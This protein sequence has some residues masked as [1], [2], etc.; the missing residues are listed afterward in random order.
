MSRIVWI[1][2]AHLNFC[3]AG[4][5][6]DFLELVRR[7]H[8]AAVLLG[9]DIGEAQ[10][11][12]DYLTRMACAWPL[13][14]YFVLGNHDFYYGSIHTVREQ[15]DTFARQ[16]PSFRYLTTNGVVELTP[17]VGLVGHDGWA[18]GRIGSYVSSV[19]MMNDY[20]LI[21]ELA[22]FSKFDRWQRLQQLG[23]EAADHIA[24]VLPD[25]LERFAHV[26]LLT[27]VPPVREA[28]WYQ[29]Q[30]SDDQWAPHFTCQAMGETIRRIMRKRPDRRLTV[31]CGH[32]HSE[33]FHQMLPNV[34]IHTG[35][36]NYG[37]PGITRIMELDESSIT[38]TGL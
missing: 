12:V 28:C 10:S 21:T 34:E 20:K 8:P 33:G 17:R 5:I 24:R 27:H 26:Y 7:E 2:D 1:T 9:G 11:V 14:V 30:I 16:N 31:L 18:D 37:Q 3:N 22:N 13:P 35:A 36:A 19:V 23:D 4:Q 38:R 25:A 29:G 6:D 32:T 15:V